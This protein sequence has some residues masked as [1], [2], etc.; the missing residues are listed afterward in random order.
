MLQNI[1]QRYGEKLRATDGEIGHVR[2]FY[3]DDKTWTV[4]YLVAD[5]GGWLKRPVGLDFSACAG[6]ALPGRKGASR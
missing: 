4:R 6:S 1:Q 2:D 5:T 3:F